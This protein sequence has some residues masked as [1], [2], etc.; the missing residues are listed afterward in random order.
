MR[1]G[2]AARR[3]KGRLRA[4]G[5]PLH[6]RVVERLAASMA[7]HASSRPGRQGRAQSAA[8]RFG[9]SRCGD[10]QR[11]FGGG[12]PVYRVPTVTRTRLGGMLGVILGVVR[13]NRDSPRHGP[14]S[15]PYARATGGR[16]R[17]AALS[18]RG[19]RM[20]GGPAG[21]P[22]RPTSSTASHGIAIRTSRATGCREHPRSACPVGHPLAH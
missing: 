6:M 4:S 11:R 10:D 2:A 16:A 19:C 15:P 9:G 20:K 1:A 14:P 3:C 7:G 18:R 22:R 13:Q 17:T 21:H 8:A 5:A 12:R